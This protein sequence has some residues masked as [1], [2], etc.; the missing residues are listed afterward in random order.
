MLKTIAIQEVIKDRPALTVEKGSTVAQAAGL[1]A[2][3]NKGA[4][5]VV[6]D[7][8]LQGIFTER[9]LL[10]RVVAKGLDANETP[11][12]AVMTR[13]LAVGGPDDGHLEAIRRMVT[14]GCR[15]LPVVE[16]GR[17]ISVVSRRELMALDI[18]QLEEE[19]HRHDPATLFI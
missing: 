13:G 19:V 11:V 10:C 15:H 9:D 7:G 16:N 12:D 8:T 5:L 3:A 14:V 1:M 6:E 4:I 2:E 17:V 18:R